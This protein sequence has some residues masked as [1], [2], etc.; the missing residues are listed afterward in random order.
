M[1][2]P[3]WTLSGESDCVRC[4]MRKLSIFAGLSIT[5][6]SDLGM[7]VKDIHLPA[8]AE[9]YRQG[10][11]ASYAFTLRS[12]AI[13][14]SVQKN[15]QPG[16]RIVRLLRDGDLLGFEGLGQARQ[17]YQHT[18]TALAASDLCLLDLATLNHLSENLPKIRQA[19]LERWQRALEDAE[20]HLAETGSGKAESSVAA[21]LCQ[22]CR[23]FPDGSLVAFPMERKDL[24]SYLG[25]SSAHVSRIMAEFKRQGYVKESGNRI[26]IERLPLLRITGGLE[27]KV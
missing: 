16:P 20:L 2:D 4:P 3:I 18:A 15:G 12:G 14:L 10:E 6:L 9:L 21:F 7:D 24:A 27:P 5:D 13:K 1:H 23:V 22:W 25:L 17:R 19:L 26:R 8:G 11:S